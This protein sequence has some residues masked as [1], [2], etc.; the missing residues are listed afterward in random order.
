MCTTV[1][2]VRFTEADYRTREGEP[3][4]ICVEGIGEIAQPAMATVS[5]TTDGTAIGRIYIWK[6]QSLL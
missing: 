4:E 3:A 5:T 6:L 2:L 1:L